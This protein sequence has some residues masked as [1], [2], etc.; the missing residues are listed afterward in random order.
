A[1]RVVA[2]IANDAAT[3]AFTVRAPDGSLSM[4]VDC[5]EHCFVDRLAV[6]GHE[7]LNAEMGL[8][9]GVRLE[10]T[11]RTSKNDAATPQLVI[12]RDEASLRMSGGSSPL[13]YVETWR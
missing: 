11:W 9:T 3:K 13:P 6:R 1:E 8:V 5:A 2:Q 10:G 12:G 4:H 7:I